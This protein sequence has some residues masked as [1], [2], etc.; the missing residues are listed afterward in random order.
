[1]QVKRAEGIKRIKH[2]VLIPYLIVNLSVNSAT[3]QYTNI[4]SKEKQ[5]Q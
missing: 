1:M 3:E 5:H 4:T 2:F